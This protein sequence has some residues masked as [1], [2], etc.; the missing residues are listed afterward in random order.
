ME[1]ICTYDDWCIVRNGGKLYQVDF[2]DLA[3]I[4]VREV[5]RIPKAR[6]KEFGELDLMDGADCPEHFMCCGEEDITEDYCYWTCL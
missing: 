3:I 2:D 6:V 4:E 1:I 5:H